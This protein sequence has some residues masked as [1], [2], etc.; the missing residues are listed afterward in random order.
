MVDEATEL[1]LAVLAE[2]IANSS[3]V[4]AGASGGIGQVWI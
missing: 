3:L 2:R 1:Y 4:V